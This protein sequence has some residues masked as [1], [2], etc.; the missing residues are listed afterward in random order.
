MTISDLQKELAK[1]KRKY[2]NI[3]V[4]VNDNFATI[5]ADTGNVSTTP[6]GEKI[7][8]VS[9]KVSQYTSICKYSDDSR[10]FLIF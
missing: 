5:A 10:A 8:A 2:G 3:T 6:D 1:A 9:M 4:K 7:V